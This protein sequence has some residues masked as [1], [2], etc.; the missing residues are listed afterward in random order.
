MKGWG[1]KNVG[2]GL[3]FAVRLAYMR[4]KQRVSSG[5]SSIKS[6]PSQSNAKGMAHRA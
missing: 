6:W 3:R 2:A 1:Q 4:L 5:V